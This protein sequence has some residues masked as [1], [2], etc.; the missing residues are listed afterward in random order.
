MVTDLLLVVQT[1]VVV[2]HHWQAFLRA[3]YIFAVRV[4][5]VA[6]EKILP[7]GKAARGA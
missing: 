1:L 6:G 3:G 4:D 5:D 7:E 2:F